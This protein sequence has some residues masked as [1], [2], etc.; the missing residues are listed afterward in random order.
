MLQEL[1]TLQCSEGTQWQG[2]A[3][4]SVLRTYRIREGA[5]LW[6]W[7]VVLQSF[8]VGRAQ[9]CLEEEDMVEGISAMTKGERH[10][11]QRCFVLRSPKTGG[12]CRCRSVLKCE[13]TGADGRR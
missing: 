11:S 6:P 9:K 8:V 13:V 10:F 12:M 4:T 3:V 1:G 2:N 7:L 5:L